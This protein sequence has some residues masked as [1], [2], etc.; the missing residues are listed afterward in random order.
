MKLAFGDAVVG[1]KHNATTVDAHAHEFDPES[2]L[3]RF[4]HIY[5]YIYIHIYVYTYIY[6]HLYAYIYTYI[7]IYI[8]IHIYTHIYTY[9]CIY[10]YLHISIYMWYI[11]MYT[12]VYNA[13]ICTY[14]LYYTATR[15]NTLQYFREFSSEIQYLI[16]SN[17]PNNVNIKPRTRSADIMQFW[18]RDPQSGR[19]ANNPFQ[20]R[21][22]IEN[23]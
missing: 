13:Y 1:M 6:T 12:Y 23:S 20:S 18:G 2:L 21:I 16:F 22:S 9:I 17:S 19:T 5:I 10:I 8:C 15:C 11:H 4:T 7:Y 3:F 14:L